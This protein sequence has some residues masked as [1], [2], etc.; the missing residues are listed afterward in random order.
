MAFDLGTLIR[1]A[2][3]GA[4]AYQQAQRQE[5]DRT[6][7]QQMEDEERARR[8]AADAR[9]IARDERDEQEWLIRQEGLKLGLERSRT[10]PPEIPR[11]YRA[12]YNGA[13]GEFETPEEAAKFV[14]QMRGLLP[15]PDERTPA[16]IEMDEL[17]RRELAARVAGA[18][19]ENEVE[20]APQAANTI[21]E[22]IRLQGSLSGQMLDPGDEAAQRRLIQRNALIRSLIHDEGLTQAEA[23]REARRRLGP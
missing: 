13:A 16:D 20:T 2:A 19:R 15:D 8:K 4:G 18:E 11:P 1:S 9:D 5:Q 22:A 23:V 7:Q 14:M 12:T 21:E 17:R 3:L 6:R 10:T